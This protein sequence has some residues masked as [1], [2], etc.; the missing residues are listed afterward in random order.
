[1]IFV[2]FCRSKPGILAHG[3]SQA[4]VAQTFR[5]KYVVCAAAMDV[6]DRFNYDPPLPEQL[7]RLPA[8]LKGKLVPK[9]LSNVF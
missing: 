8:I 5:G 4:P 9:A 3:T 7:R 1:M 6:A 2:D